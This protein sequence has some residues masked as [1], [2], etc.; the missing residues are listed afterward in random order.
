MTNLKGEGES[1][2]EFVDKS[3]MSKSVAY[4]GEAVKES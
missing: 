3:Q 4:I 1:Q 2:N